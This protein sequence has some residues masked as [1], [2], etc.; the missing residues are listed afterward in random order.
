M[1]DPGLEVANPLDLWGTGRDTEQL[2]AS[3]LTAL[4][5][6]PGVGAVALAVD[7]VPEFDGDDS[8]RSAVLAVAARTA[9][10]VAVL[11]SVPAA[12]DRAVAARLRD[13]GVP[14]LESTRSGLL[15]LRHLLSP[16]P[17]PPPAPPPVSRR[18][19]RPV[20]GP[21][22]GRPD[23]APTSSACSATTASPPCA[24]ARPAR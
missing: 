9:K 15:A 11:A 4:A 8:Y 5:G 13:A 3:A 12:I 6:D 22:D 16:R 14:V 24:R 10:P 21:A 18:A 7:L 19:S 1:L 2:F 17:E 23:A 20:G